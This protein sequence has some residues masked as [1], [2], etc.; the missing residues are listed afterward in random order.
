[1]R[2]IITASQYPPRVTNVP[3][4]VAAHAPPSHPSVP[5]VPPATPLSPPAPSSHPSSVIVCV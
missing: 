2:W 4:I 5:S 1:M 3:T